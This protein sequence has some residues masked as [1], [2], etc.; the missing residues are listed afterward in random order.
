M[1][2]ATQ[3]GA[4]T[5]ESA[6]FQHSRGMS[7]AE[8]AYMRGPK[9]PA[10]GSVPRSTSKYL[11]SVLFKE[12]FATMSLRRFG[13]DV[14][15]TYDI[16]DMSRGIRDV[17]DY[18][19]AARLVAEERDNNPV[20]ARWLDERRGL[21]IDLP[22]MEKCAPG[23]LGKVLHEFIVS[24]GME[25]IFINNYEAKNDLDYFMRQMGH[26]HDIQHLVTGFGP[27]IAG[28]IALSTM[29][30]RSFPRFMSAALAHHANVANSF[31]TSA[32]FSRTLFN[33]PDGVEMLFDAL[34][35]GIEAGEKVKQPLFM[36]DYSTYFD[37]R[38]E[39]I[40]AD[41]GFERGPG[42]AWFISEEIMAG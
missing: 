20:F 21:G 35:L 8:I 30:L 24:S 28:E 40:T 41:L 19:E 42:D 33:Y 9:E 18:A 11:N 26:T 17:T 37:W 22:R 16:P 6:E 23:T 31:V 29:N 38:L 15:N 3:A 13:K 39:D 1:D 5:A 10:A 27:N 32:S 14:A 2:T 12:A 7:P 25:M 34:K 36:I 4:K